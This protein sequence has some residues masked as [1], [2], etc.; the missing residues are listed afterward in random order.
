MYHCWNKI[1]RRKSEWMT[2]SWNSRLATTRSMRSMAFGIARFMPRSQQ[3][4]YQGFTIWSCGKATLRRKI[5]RSPHWRF[6][7]FKGSSPPT[8]K[9]IQKSWQRHLTLLIWLRRWLGH[10]LH[11]GQQPSPRQ[12]DLLSLRRL[13]SRN[14]VDLFGLPPPPS[15]Q[16]SLRPLSCSIFFWFSS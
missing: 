13:Q 4:N 15:E 5:P 1:L 2:C 7:T 3:A 12:A 16:K 11:L 10:L 6:S 14:A 9:I 8:T